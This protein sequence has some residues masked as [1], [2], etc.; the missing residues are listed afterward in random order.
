MTD[1]QLHNH[2]ITL[3]SCKDYLISGEQYQLRKNQQY[4]MLVT[5]PIPSNLE[6]YYDSKEY[7]SHHNSK[8]TVV[9]LLYNSIKKWSFNLKKSLFYMKSKKQSILDIGAGTGDFLLYCKKKGMVIA[10]VEPNETARKK[11][12]SKGLSLQPDI[13]SVPNKQYD[14]ITL[15]HALE[16][17]PNLFECVNQLK[18][19]LAKSG[20]MFIA[21]PN[22]KSFDANY[23]NEFWAA[24]DVPRHL[25]HFSQKSIH[26]IFESVEMKVTKIHPLKFDSFY[27]SLL[28]EKYKTGKMNFIKAFAVGLYS[29][30]KALR[31][32]EFS[33]L[34]YQIEHK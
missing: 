18:K 32:N 12:L 8:K 19:C 29:N 16:H 15:W 22:F 33:S 25:W 30:I 28:S 14:V 7:I 2:T 24:Y 13:K 17:I 21:V 4:E 26:L 9:H 3:F 34:I 10:G 1:K 6:K 23:Y 5:F 27:V 11:A 31:S 20:K